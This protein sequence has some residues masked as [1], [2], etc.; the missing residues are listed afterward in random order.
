[1]YPATTKLTRT[2]HTKSPLHRLDPP[3]AAVPGRPEPHPAALGRRVAGAVGSLD[4]QA[5]VPELRCGPGL[6]PGERPENG[7]QAAPSGAG[8]GGV[9]AAEPV[10]FADLAGGA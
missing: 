8:D 2:H 3:L 4:Q 6:G 9:G 5:H 10:G 1:M 7:G